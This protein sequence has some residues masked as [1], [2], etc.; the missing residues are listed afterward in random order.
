MVAVLKKKKKKDYW[1]I[2]KGY[3]SG[4]ARWE[5]HRARYVAGGP[6]R[7]CRRCSPCIS[8]YSPTGKVF[9]PVWRRQGGWTLWPLVTELTFQPLSSPRR[10]GPGLKVPAL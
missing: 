4:T 3:H 1:F 10:L 5:R 6:P 2:I 9:K 7:L 8:T